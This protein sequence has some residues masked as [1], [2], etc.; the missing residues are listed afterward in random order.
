MAKPHLLLVDDDVQSLRVLEVSLRKAGYAV[1]GAMSGTE[2]LGRLAEVVPD[3]IIADTRL[4]GMDGLAFCAEVRKRAALAGV[5]FIFLT[6]DEGMEDRVRGLE[7]GVEDY[8][9]K[10]IYVRELLVRV[11][12]VLQRW[13]RRS[14]TTESGAQRT[15]FSGQLSDMA[16]VDLVQTVE[17]SRKSGVVRLRD[18]AGRRASMHFRD[19]RVIDADVGRLLGA[20][21][22]YRLLTWTEGSFE[23][24]F[25]PARRRDVI[26]LQPQALLMEGMRRLDEWS[27][28]CEQLPAL[29]VPIEVDDGELAARLAEIPDEM[30]AVFRL[31]DGRRTLID[32]V[33]AGDLSDLEALGILVKLHAEG[34]VRPATDGVPEAMPYS[35]SEPSTRPSGPV[36]VRAEDGLARTPSGLPAGLTDGV[37]DVEQDEG[38]QAGSFELD[39]FLS[40]EG[41]GGEGELPP[42]SEPPISWMHPESEPETLGLPEPVSSAVPSQP[43][44][45]E[46]ARV[47]NDPPP[48]AGESTAEQGADASRGPDAKREEGRGDRDTP[49]APAVL[50]A[51]ELVR[52]AEA[53]GLPVEDPTPLP[54][55]VAAWPEADSGGTNAGK[56]ADAF[57]PFDDAAWHSDHAHP[58]GEDEEE[59]YDEAPSRAGLYAMGVGAVLLAGAGLLWAYGGK[60]ALRAPKD[61]VAV[62]APVK[63]EAVAALAAPAQVAQPAVAV[64]PDTDKASPPAGATPSD[65]DKASPPVGATPPD[66]SKTS[67]PVGAALPDTDKALP[68][69][70]AAPPGT[71]EAPPPAE[72]A[73]TAPAPA[74]DAEFEKLLKKGSALAEQGNRRAIGL[75]E[76]AL[77]MK[78]GNGAAL[79]ALANAELQ[80]GQTARALDHAN[81][82]IAADPQ[83]ADGFLVKGALE[84]QL[85]HRAEAR[86]AYE[87]YLKLAPHG[88]YASDLRAV[89]KSL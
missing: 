35:W 66:T 49:S 2:A 48:M 28:L 29:D 5:P 14:L 79:A 25:R 88:K 34:L 86:A 9:A 10:P 39:A 68:P 84:Q 43:V 55:P 12:A 57:D 30:N 53:Q 67:P 3:L 71:G 64:P 60:H 36:P 83:N 80:Q 78:P 13:R 85:K 24:E 23:L 74:D 17:I 8:L 31:I 26:E 61:G 63:P 87:Q 59:E 82:A 20:E 11:R 4:P 45:L 73:P 47:G 44:P 15:R 56:A 75:L 19:G 18:A 37:E 69:V 16:V 7:L 22:V 70:G 72:A 77:T 27:H 46:H 38:G 58:H 21:A 65:T 54:R 50:V 81:E 33:D 1:T 40:G 62:T 52:E 6:G 41:L 76:K 32:V 51:A 89:L 42:P